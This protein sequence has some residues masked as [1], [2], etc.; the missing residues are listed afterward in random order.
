MKLNKREQKIVGV[1]AII[2]LGTAFIFFV[3]GI[4]FTTYNHIQLLG[5]I[6]VEEINLNLN[7]SL[8]VDLALK[9]AREEQKISCNGLA[10]KDSNMKNEI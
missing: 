3:F 2:I 10:C 6:D 8:I 4:M 5:S 7:E 9:A 1:C